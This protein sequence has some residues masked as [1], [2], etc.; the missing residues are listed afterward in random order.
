[1]VPVT[2]RFR[3]NTSTDVE[4]VRQLRQQQRRHADE[5]SDHRGL[6]GIGIAHAA[7]LAR[8]PFQHVGVDVGGLRRRP[9]LDGGVGRQR[10]RARRHR[11]AGFGCRVMSDRLGQQVVETSI[12]AALGGGVVDFEQ[13][14]GFGPA[15][16]LMLDRARGQDAG[17]PGGV[18]GIERAG[19]MDTA[20]GGRAFAGD[21]AI[22]H[23][24]QRLGS[25]LAAG[26]LERTGRSSDAQQTWTG[27]GHRSYVS[28]SIIGQDFPL[29][30]NERLT[31]RNSHFEI[32]EVV[33]W[34]L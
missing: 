28:I 20:P 17:A 19:K 7:H 32:S 34:S 13:R 29:G 11:Q 1:M 15:D 12:V 33:I 10:D 21:H 5:G 30:I 9:A 23:D 18:I 14:F 24:G 27:G 2:C 8:D 4:H 6:R 31:I 22:A 3:P 25:G 16:R 26:R